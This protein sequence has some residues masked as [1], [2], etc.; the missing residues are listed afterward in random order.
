MGIDSI[1]S[2]GITSITNE[3]KKY[4]AMVNPVNEEFQTHILNVLKDLVKRY[5][6]LDGLMLDRVRYDGIT[7]DFSDLSSEVRGVYRAESRKVSGRHLRM[8]KG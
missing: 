2:E 4:S 8:E 7:A 6:D 1:H 5:P 3:K